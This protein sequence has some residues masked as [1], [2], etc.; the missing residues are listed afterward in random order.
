[1]QNQSEMAQHN[2]F[3]SGIISKIIFMVP[4]MKIC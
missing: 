4:F 2:A 1:M 3:V